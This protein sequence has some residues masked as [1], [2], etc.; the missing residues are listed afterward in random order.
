MSIW[1]KFDSFQM[2]TITKAWY[3]KHGSQVKQRTVEQ[4]ILHRERYGTSGNCYDLAI[5]LLHEF[6]NH[7][8]VS[9]GVLTPDKHVAVVAI[10]E[11]GNRYLCDL[12]DQWIEP[13]LIDPNHETYTEQYLDG[14][15]PGAQIKLNSH[16]DNLLIVTYRRPNGK[17][18]TQ[19]YDLNPVQDEIIWLEAEKTQCTLTSPLVEKRIFSHDEVMHWEY[20]NG[21]S[22]YSSTKG[23]LHEDPLNSIEAWADRINERTGM[24]KEIVV[25][26]LY[27]YARLE[28]T[29]FL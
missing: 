2:E 29:S 23:K 1:R 3:S 15:F 28:G 27:V 12:G 9:Y 20:D 22:F 5:W 14:F 7:N 10:N 16:D 24:N 4:M 8:I 18:L 11:Y 13:I 25:Q 26:A 21:V 19:S 6:R 17:V